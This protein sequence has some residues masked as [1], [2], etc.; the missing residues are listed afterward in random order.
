VEVGRRAAL[1]RCFR[2]VLRELRSF[3]RLSSFGLLVPLAQQVAAREVYVF[4]DSGADMGNYFDLPGQTPPADSPYY[5]GADG[6]YR[7]SD[8]PMWPELLFPGM[9]SSVDAR[10]SGTLVNF[11]YGGAKSDAWLSLD[12]PLPLGTLNQLDAF[13][14]ELAAKTLTAGPKSVAFLYAGTNDLIEAIEMG[15]DPVVRIAAVTANLQRAVTRL[16]A[17]GVR[18][19]Y[20][21]EI[22]DFG[23]APAFLG[24][25]SNVQ[26]MIDQVPPL[27]RGATRSGLAA[28]AAMLDGKTRVVFLPLNTFFRAVLADPAAFGFTNV[29][30]AFYNGENAQLLATGPQRR[31]GYFFLDA[32]HTTARAQALEARL[33]GSVREAV[34][35]TTQRRLG[36]ILDG[37]GA[38]MDLLSRA[39]AAPHGADTLFSSENRRWEVDLAIPV[40]RDR[41]DGA[42]GEPQAGFDTKAAIASLRWP[43]TAVPKLALS[44]AYLG[45]EG[46]IDSHALRADQQGFACAITNTVTLGPVRLDAEVTSGWFDLETRRDPF[47]LRREKFESRGKS[48]TMANRARVAAS[49]VFGLGW[50]DLETSAGVDY[51]RTELRPFT[52]DG[53]LDLDLRVAKARYD[54]VRS[55]LGFTLRTKEWALTS[56]LKIRPE[57]EVTGRYQFADRGA[58]ITAELLDNTAGPISAEVTHGGRLAGLVEPR[59]VL[60]L[61]G[62]AAATVGYRYETAGQGYSHSTFWLN[63]TQRF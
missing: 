59:L 13:E 28:T 1:A 45:Q 49:H 23:R 55:S 11:A 39:L 5:R 10:R 44:F 51:L 6:F 34:E 62:H 2:R 24:L 50:L 61:C 38:G 57:V 42:R 58:T 7:L 35:G 32:L 60:P 27:A 25:P 46:R 56:W 31:A 36:R 43:K 22:A 19:I 47:G 54:S 17:D 14:S 4:G 15:E 26:E 30:D 9:H 63:L 37:T 3:W 12:E 53:A 41:I 29:T 40:A 48:H 33:Y 21:S 8:G 20:V 52:E 16:S 18:T